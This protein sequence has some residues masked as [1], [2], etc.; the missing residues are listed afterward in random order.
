MTFTIH[1]HTGE[2]RSPRRRMHFRIHGTVFPPTPVRI[3]A[4]RHRR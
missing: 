4:L 3:D 1:H 2:M